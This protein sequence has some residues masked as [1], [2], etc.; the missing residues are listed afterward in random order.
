MRAVLSLVISMT[1]VF[2]AA[3]AG[4]KTE[5]NKSSN[6][7]AGASGA[8]MADVPIVFPFKDFPSVETAAKAG[9]HVLVPSYNWIEDAASKGADQVT[10]IWYSQTMK[11]PGRDFSEIEFLGGEVKTVPNA[12]IVAI[13]RGQEAKK[14]DI[15]VTW[16]QSGS[17]LQRA[18]V[19]DDKNPAQPVVR[20]LS[21]G[22]SFEKDEQLK[23]NSF[24]VA[25]DGDQGT[26]VA[27]DEGS[28]TRHA[29]LIREAGDKV[30][31]VGFA[32]RVSVHPKS[33]M[34]S[35]PV[36]V[37]LNPGDKV[38][39]VWV[40]T[41]KDA[42]VKSVDARNGRVTINWDADGKEAVVVYGEL[43]KSSR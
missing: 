35:V 5:A 38:K 8:A 17:G 1:L 39:A 4:Q 6:A 36:K 25:K 18:I 32:G 3:C 15:V 2:T 31:V 9:E 10:F 33:S 40:G 12:Y 43:L 34:K 42:T 27:I 13:P 11:N 41:F 19:V 23:P 30:F 7:P 28:S 21:S 14:G 16:W 29:T 20:Y 22:S 26:A 37:S 24:F